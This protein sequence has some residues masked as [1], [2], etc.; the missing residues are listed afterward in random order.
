VCC[1]VREREKRERKSARERAERC[2]H[3]SSHPTLFHSIHTFIISRVLL[4]HLFHCDLKE[5]ERKTA[6]RGKG[7]GARGA[8]RGMGV[9]FCGPRRRCW[10]PVLPATTQTSK[11]AGESGR[12]GGRERE[13]ERKGHRR[14]EQEKSRTSSFFVCLYVFC[15]R[16]RAWVS[17]SVGFLCPFRFCWMDWGGGGE[18]ENARR[19][20]AR[21]RERAKR[22]SAPKYIN[23]LVA[24]AL[25]PCPSC[26]AEEGAG[27][28][29]EREEGTRASE[30]KERKKRKQKSTHRHRPPTPVWFISCYC[31]CCC[32]WCCCFVRVST[33]A[34][35][36]PSSTCLFLLIPRL[37]WPLSPL[38]L[39]FLPSFLPFLHRLPARRAS[40]RYRPSLTEPTSPSIHIHHTA[41]KH[42]PPSPLSFFPSSSLYTPPHQVT[43]SRSHS[44]LQEL[45]RALQHNINT[46]VAQGAQLLAREPLVDARDVELVEAGQDS[47]FCGVWSGW[48]ERV[49]R[50]AWHT[51]VCLSLSLST[52][53]D[54]NE[55]HTQQQT[56]QNQN[57]HTHTHNKQQKHAPSPSS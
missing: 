24:A 27:S 10:R 50:S 29:R 3:L 49:C 5:G 9:F 1:C 30:N 11:H 13:G 54:R 32:C 42:P 21:A 38:L 45:V 51:I 57:T 23:H 43:P 14:S 6:E 16:A 56:T 55:A 46:R 31:Y 53:T 17:A 15:L 19:A 7:G 41:R 25:L 26:R 20:R 47:L 35:T 44:L 48:G 2:L 39:S 37:F 33:R 36:C 8:G 34:I 22:Q 4:F 40:I 52:H 28:E 18:R 12:V